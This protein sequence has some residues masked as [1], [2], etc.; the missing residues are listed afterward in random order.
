ML[1]WRFYHYN[2]VLSFKF[3]F[4]NALYKLLVLKLLSL[5]ATQILLK[6][7]THFFFTKNPPPPD[8]V[9]C[10]CIFSLVKTNRFLSES[11]CR[12]LDEPCS[13]N[14]NAPGGVVGCV[15]FGVRHWSLV[16]GGNRRVSRALWRWVKEWK[17]SKKWVMFQ[18][19]MMD[20]LGERD[21]VVVL[22]CMFRVEL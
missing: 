20:L 22:M 9:D 4:F 12:C 15:A 10:G 7:K 5:C 19:K 3:A 13:A 17:V 1:R 6:K 21:L 2:I 16:N 14:A 18:Q 11:S 8:M